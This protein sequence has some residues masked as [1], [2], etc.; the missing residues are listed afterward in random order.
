MLKALLVVALA[1]AALVLPAC[2]T[3]EF[4]S[5]GDV[6]VLTDYMVGSFSSAKQAQKDPENYRD[7]RLEMVPIWPDRADGTWLYVEQAVASSLDRPY[8]QRIYRLSANTDGTLR[9]DVFTLPEPALKFAGAWREP[10]K[11][12]G[13]TPEQLELK[14]GCAITLTWHPCSELFT[15]S[16]TGT[17]CESTLQGAAYATSEVSINTYGMI[18]W[19][20]G[21]DRAGNQVWG[22]TEGGY[23]FVKQSNPQN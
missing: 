13:L 11:L 4:R 12:A 17:G 18:T 23:I 19:D 21:F 2:N 5:T 22:A 3:G 15:G 6:A 16:T 10:A 20:R 8:R 9:S 14:D 7:I 1:A